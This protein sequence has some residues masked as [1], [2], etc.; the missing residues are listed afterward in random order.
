[1]AE[2]LTAAGIAVGEI[3]PEPTP[4]ERQAILLAL[5]QL[6]PYLLP[7]APAVSVTDTAWRFSGRWWNQGKLGA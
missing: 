2:R 4:E 5:E 6:V 3:T 7:P 1:M